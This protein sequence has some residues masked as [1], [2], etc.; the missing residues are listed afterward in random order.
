MAAVLTDADLERIRVE[1]GDEP[2]DDVLQAKQARLRSDWR[3]VAIEVMQRRL[4]D[5]L[6]QPSSFSVKGGLY[7]ESRAANIAGY[8]RAIKRLKSAAMAAGGPALQYRC[9]SA[10]DR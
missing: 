7:G 6:D 1:V 8:E 10:W 3:W 9:D 4:T 2:A 5:L